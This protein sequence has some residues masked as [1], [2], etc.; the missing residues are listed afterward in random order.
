[1]E[2]LDAAAVAE[3]EKRAFSEPW[4]MSEFE[5]AAGNS[6]YV[7]L[8]A[9]EDKK[10]VGYANATFAADESDVTNI[11][12]AE[13]YRGLGIG[14]KLLFLLTEELKKNAAQKTFL[15]VRVSNEPAKALYGK[16][17]FEITG[18]RKNFYRNPQEDAFLMMKE[19]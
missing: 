1:M 7:C 12:V 16:L 15:E 10:V 18:R 13:E 4:P 19:L 11:A 8:V 6:S 3:I 2:V 5:K 9:L 14:E 17:G